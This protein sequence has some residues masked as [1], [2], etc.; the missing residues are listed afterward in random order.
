MGKSQKRSRFGNVKR[1]GKKQNLR[2]LLA[3]KAMKSFHRGVKTKTTELKINGFT[4]NH[5]G[6][7]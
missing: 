1:R 6:F 5:E 3:F 7:R 4:L 2:P